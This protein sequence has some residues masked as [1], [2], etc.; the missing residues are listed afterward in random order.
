MS[1]WMGREYDRGLEG[2]QLGLEVRIFLSVADTFEALAARRPYREDLTEEE[3]MGI[4]EKKYRD[5]VGW[6]LRGG[7]A[8]GIFGEKSVCVWRWWRLSATTTSATETR[9]AREETRKEPRRFFF[10]GVECMG[11]QA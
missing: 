2:A 3:V 7:A 5:G 8:G 10:C 9:E 1:G 11:I 4:L 6:E